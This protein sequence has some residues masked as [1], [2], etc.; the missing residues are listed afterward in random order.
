MDFNI[1][2]KL[3]YTLKDK[4]ITDLCKDVHML[5]AKTLTDKYI[6]Y[7]LLDTKGVTFGSDTCKSDI[8]NCQL[9]IFSKKDFVAIYEV[10][11]RV[12]GEEGFSIY[13]DFDFFEDEGK[14]YVKTLRFRYKNYI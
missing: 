2:D 4:R 11:K 3:R 6:V 14:Y 7:Q 8:F 1:Y 12:L 5:N 9:Q 10:V 13:Q